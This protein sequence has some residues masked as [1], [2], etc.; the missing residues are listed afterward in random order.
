LASKTGG[1][2]LHPGGPVPFTILMGGDDRLYPPDAMRPFAAL[3]PHA[4]VE[5]VE[6]CGHLAPL[7]APEAVASAI[8][9]LANA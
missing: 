3:A 7:E 9:R 8:R 4:V 2:Q 6:G 5:V 1:S